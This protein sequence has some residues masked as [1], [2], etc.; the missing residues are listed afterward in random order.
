MEELK[1]K[2]KEFLAVLERLSSALE[3]TRKVTSETFDDAYLITFCPAP[4]DSSL[5][6]LLPPVPVDNGGFSQAPFVLVS[7]PPIN[8]ADVTLADLSYSS[9]LV[10]DKSSLAN[11]ETPVVAQFTLD[12]VRQVV[13]SSGHSPVDAS[14]H[15]QSHSLHRV[16]LSPGLIYQPLTNDEARYV[17]SLHSLAL[18]ECN[19]SCS[20]SVPDVY[21]ISQSMGQGEQ[22]GDVS[23]QGSRSTVSHG[24]PGQQMIS[25]A[26]VKETDEGRCTPLSSASTS[27]LAVYE[28]GPGMDCE[29]GGALVVAEMAWPNPKK[30]LQPPPVTANATLHVATTFGSLTSPLHRIYQ[31]LTYLSK[32]V[33]IVDKTVLFYMPEVIPSQNSPFSLE[34][35]LSEYEKMATLSLEHSPES[36][37]T[38]DVTLNCSLDDHSIISLRQITDFLEFLWE[39]LHTNMDQVQGTFHEVFQLVMA[40]RVQPFLLRS[41]TSS[42]ASLIR[43]ILSPQESSRHLQL[44]VKEALSSDNLTTHFAQLGLLKIAQDIR[45][46]YASHRLLPRA[47]LQDLT[48][49]D[50]KPPAEAFSTLMCYYKA[51]EVALVAE[52]HFSIMGTTLHPLTRTALHYFKENTSHSGK[53]SPTFQLSFPPQSEGVKS[54]A[55]LCQHL[56]PTIWRATTAEGKK[57]KLFVFSSSPLLYGQSL[58]LLDTTAVDSMYVYEVTT[59]CTK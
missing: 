46:V 35:F 40:K 12:E 17:L 42:L 30:A 28:A 3:S 33:A 10:P 57:E 13:C 7:K 56:Q 44:E 43:K 20:S 23:F 58:Q 6:R 9:D 1:Q 50:S 34:S 59:H 25:A 4:S 2:A 41:N 26:A 38:S 19:T 54:I 24:T 14:A 22:D 48:R 31:E 18:R 11:P 36:M 8:D 45:Y 52:L 32:Y 39:K 5:H 15:A 27:A 51:L 49:V 53:C 16:R 47:D 21:T 55:S 29:E 37:L